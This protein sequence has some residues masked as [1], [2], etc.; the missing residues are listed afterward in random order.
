MLDPANIASIEQIELAD[1]SQLSETE[2]ATCEY[3][4]GQTPD[5]QLA[6][7]LERAASGF[8]NSGGGIFVAGVNDG[9]IADGGIA[10]A[11]GRQSRVDWVDQVLAKVTPRGEYA[12]RVLE[13]TPPTG[14]IEAD[15]GVLV[16]GFK[17]SNTAPHMASDGRYYV[18][19][20]AHTVPA[21]HFIV[22]AIRARRGVSTPI[23]TFFL[24][25][26][27]DYSRLA[28]L[29]LVNVSSVPAL[30][31]VA[32]LAPAP[33]LL[34]RTGHEEV[35]VR[36]LDA[37]HPA[38]IP[39][40]FMQQGPNDWQD[41][42]ERYTMR[43]VYKDL[44]G[45]VYEEEHEFLPRDDLPKPIGDLPALERIAVAAERIESRLGLIQRTR[46]Q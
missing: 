15:Q 41:V 31:L 30:D 24:R 35:R 32:T 13:G 21:T 10:T 7:K 18:R 8:W 20:G 43:L 37:A 9:G 45:R 25:P 19:A 36:A 40:T 27:A 38:R 1:L 28:E 22:E 29:E 14:S 5:R 2:D 42:D 12:A 3:K 6:T 17:E 34:R 33:P 26:K 39:F 4:G 46:V 44:L 23:I 16:V 11:V